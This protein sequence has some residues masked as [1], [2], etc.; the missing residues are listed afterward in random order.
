MLGGFSVLSDIPQAALGNIRPAAVPSHGS[1]DNPTSGTL[2]RVFWK[3]RG[4]LKTL[5][6]TCVHVI[7]W[8]ISHVS[9]LF[10][11]VILFFWKLS[12]KV[13][14]ISNPLI[15]HLWHPDTN[16]TFSQSLLKTQWDTYGA[17]WTPLLAYDPLLT[18][19]NLTE[20]VCTAM[21]PLIPLSVHWTYFKVNKQ[22]QKN[23]IKAFITEDLLKPRSSFG[24]WSYWTYG[25]FL[26]FSWN[27]IKFLFLKKWYRCA[28][29][30]PFM[31]I[32]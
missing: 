7:F 9:E 14:T 2:S 3:E 28:P 29:H 16:G 6:T 25:A 8:S 18:P 20:S 24:F 12:E 11:G 17:F 23:Q 21:Q 4:C 30:A 22:K 15:P 19:A 27:K 26:L 31:S 5:E 1:D 10:H 13:D 32:F